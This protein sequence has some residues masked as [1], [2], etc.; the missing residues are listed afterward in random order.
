MEAPAPKLDDK[1]QKQ[2]ADAVVRLFDGQ[3]QRTDRA[4]EQV[5]RLSANYTIRFANEPGI[6]VVDELLIRA[7]LGL[8]FYRE[9]TAANWLV[10]SMAARNLIDKQH[11]GDA[12]IG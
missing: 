11:F 3:T 5:L 12:A 7:V 10:N 1:I 6:F 8:G 4:L 2:I 9:K